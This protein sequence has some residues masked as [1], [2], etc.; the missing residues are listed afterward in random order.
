MPRGKKF[1]AERIIGKF[2]EAEVG[3]AQGKTVPEVVR[4]LGVTERTYYR[5]KRDYGG[6]RTDQA[7][8]LKDIEKEN[9]RRSGARGSSTCA[10][11]QPSVEKV[12]HDLFQLGRPQET[13]RV[14]RVDGHRIL[15]GQTCPTV[16]WA[17]TW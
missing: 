17:V 10:T 15:L 12:I 13:P 6:L 14:S 9:A 7:K 4:K 5:W 16:C 2:R 8:R 3:L 1:T 11:C